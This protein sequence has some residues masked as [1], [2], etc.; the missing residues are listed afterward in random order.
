MEQYDVYLKKIQEY[1]HKPDVVDSDDVISA[2]SLIEIIE[3]YMGEL[4]KVIN[5]P[6]IDE[7]N[8]NRALVKKNNEEI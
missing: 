3:N 6:L 1:L 4:K 5:S 7:I 2:H 8:N